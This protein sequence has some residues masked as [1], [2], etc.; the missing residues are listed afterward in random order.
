MSHCQAPVRDRRSS[1]V[2]WSCRPWRGNPAAGSR[3]IA[4]STSC[5]TQAAKPEGWPIASSSEPAKPSSPSVLRW[6]SASSARASGQCRGERLHRPAVLRRLGRQAHVAYRR[7]AGHDR[8]E[9]DLDRARASPAWAG[10][11]ALPAARPAARRASGRR[12]G[13]SADRLVEAHLRAVHRQREARLR[14]QIDESPCPRRSR[15]CRA[16]RSRTGTR[17]TPAACGRV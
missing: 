10:R 12:L 7:V 8:R 14:A 1:A 17:R 16:G 2:R 15:D 13:V 3:R 9:I 11:A 5:D 4:S 6:P